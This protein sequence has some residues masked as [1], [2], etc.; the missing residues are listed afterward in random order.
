MYSL[1]FASHAWMWFFVTGRTDGQ[2]TGWALQSG[3]IRSTA[4]DLF[5]IWSR[6]ILQVS[7]M[8]F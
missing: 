4:I 8:L 2:K 7:L 1:L 5:A 6:A 3:F